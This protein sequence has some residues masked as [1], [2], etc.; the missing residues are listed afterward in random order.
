V[1]GRNCDSIFGDET[2]L[3]EELKVTQ[4]LGSSKGKPPIGTLIWDL[5]TD[6]RLKK[7]INRIEFFSILF[8]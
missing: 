2:S 3:I 5:G 1:S 4:Y 6:I 7:I 8:F